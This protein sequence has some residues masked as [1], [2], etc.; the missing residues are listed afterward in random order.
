MPGDQFS[1]LWKSFHRWIMFH[2]I[3]NHSPGH[4]AMLVRGINLKTIVHVFCASV[5]YENYSS[6]QSSNKD[7][8]DNVYR[9][10]YQVFFFTF[11]NEDDK[12]DGEIYQS[13]QSIF[14]SCKKTLKLIVISW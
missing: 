4:F 2:R 9:I 11:V 1:I 8:I 13:S 5:L 3:E 6:L 12:S 7:V 10:R 14:K